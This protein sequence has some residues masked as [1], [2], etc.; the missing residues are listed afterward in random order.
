MSIRS[1]AALIA[2]ALAV[3]GLA[4]ESP[5]LGVEATPEE[6]AEWEISIEPD[7]EGLPPGSGT[8]VE[9]AP[10]YT[11]Y[12]FACHGAE[13][14]G[15][16]NDVL[17]GGHGTLKGPA[18][19]KTVGSFWP[20]ATTVFDYIRRTMPYQQPQSLSDDQVYALTAYLLFLN[21]IIEEDEVMDAKTLPEVRMPNR[22]NFI[23]AYPPA[24]KDSE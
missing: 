21:G 4:Q 17:V 7:G 23:L 11:L 3:G 8:A 5:D 15:Q 16:L 22:D 18:P 24:E 1:L 13:G 10:V 20:Y 2:A 9:G 19:L 14:A 12:C 6:V